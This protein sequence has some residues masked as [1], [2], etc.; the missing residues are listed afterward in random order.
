V[1]VSGVYTSLCLQHIETGACAGNEPASVE[2]QVATVAP[3][4]VNA[5]WITNAKTEW[6][7]S[8]TVLQARGGM[9]RGAGQENIGRIEGR[10]TFIIRVVLGAPM[11]QKLMYTYMDKS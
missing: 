6:P 2:E 3:A 5:M 7:S 8:R 4:S 10:Y 9:N 1:E 11:A